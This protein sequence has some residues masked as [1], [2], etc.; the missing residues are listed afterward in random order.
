MYPWSEFT[1]GKFA[2]DV[3]VWRRKPNLKI[4]FHLIGVERK[5]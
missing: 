4:Y 3:S 2:I 5:L 1:L